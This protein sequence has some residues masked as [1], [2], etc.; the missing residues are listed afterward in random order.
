[1]TEFFGCMVFLWALAMLIGV[2]MIEYR[3]SRLQRMMERRE[4][5]DDAR[6]Y[7]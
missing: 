1:M 2:V 4:K 7:L 3:L 6:G 5:R